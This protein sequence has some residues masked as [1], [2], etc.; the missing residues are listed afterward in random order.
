[1]PEWTTMPPTEPGYYWAYGKGIGDNEPF[2][3]RVEVSIYEG[4]ISFEFDAS[5]YEF[6]AN[7]DPKDMTHWLGP[8][9]APEPPQE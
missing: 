6:E 4:K 7:I 8:E 2:V 5:G 1:M 9:S 3:Y